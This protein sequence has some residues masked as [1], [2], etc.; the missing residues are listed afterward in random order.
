MSPCVL[1][2][3]FKYRLLFTKPCKKDWFNQPWESRTWPE[4]QHVA[5]TNTSVE[6]RAFD[7]KDANTYFN[8]SDTLI[9]LVSKGLYDCVCS[10]NLFYHRAVHPR[11]RAVFKFAGKHFLSARPCS[12]HNHPSRALPISQA[13]NVGRTREAW[14]KQR[15]TALYPLTCQHGRQ[16]NSPSSI[17]GIKER[18]HWQWKA[19]SSQQHKHTHTHTQWKLS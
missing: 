8:N 5:N 4:A 13:W 10:N 17:N 1:C 14:P 9:L 18:L 6:W 2:D 19:R 15:Q 12:L 3:V 11:V 7:S 16:M